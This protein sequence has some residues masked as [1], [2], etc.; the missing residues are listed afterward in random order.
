VFF[1]FVL[2]LVQ[3]SV[4]SYISSFNTLHPSDPEAPDIAKS[5]REGRRIEWRGRMD[6]KVTIQ[7]TSKDLI[8]DL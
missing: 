6:T 8:P 7:E 5:E 4:W 1:L 3:L 2:F